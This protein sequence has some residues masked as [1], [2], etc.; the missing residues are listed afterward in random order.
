MVLDGE[1]WLETRP[2]QISFRGHTEAK[3]Y[4]K[5]ITQNNQE[6]RVRNDIT[7]L[8]YILHCMHDVCLID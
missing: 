6:T 4:L 8:P 5:Y 1:F 2:I 7:N 3:H